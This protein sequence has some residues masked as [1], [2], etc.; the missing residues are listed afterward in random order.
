M[1]DRGPNAHTIPTAFDPGA[2]AL[3]ATILKAAAVEPIVEAT[4]N[5]VDCRLLKSPKGFLLPIANYHDKVGQK[6]TL[7]IRVDGE[8]KNVTS[9][10]HGLL[11]MKQT[12]GVVVVTIPELGY[13]DVLRLE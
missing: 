13:G 6:V 9:A 4:P 5:L 8:I 10:Y 11:E 12:K 3:L 7:R 1:P 2:R